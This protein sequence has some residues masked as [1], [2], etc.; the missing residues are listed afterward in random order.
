MKPMVGWGAPHHR[1]S[2][3]SHGKEDGM[4]MMHYIMMSAARRSSIEEIER[5]HV[6]HA[7]GRH[8]RLRRSA[9]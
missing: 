7:V 2:I 8:R 9:Q 4:E 3:P 6:R 5:Y 1:P